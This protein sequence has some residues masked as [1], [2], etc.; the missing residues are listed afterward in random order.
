MKLKHCKEQEEIDTI[1]TVYDEE[2]RTVYL[3]GEVNLNT[4]QNIVSAIRHLDK[5]KGNITFVINSSGG[6]AAAGFAIADA[7]K[8]TKSKVIAVCL[9]E[10]MSI[11]MTILQSCDSRMSAPNCR[12]MIHNGSWSVPDL[13]V[14]Q[15]RNHIK[16]IQALNEQIYDSLTEK[17][18][19]VKSEVEKMCETET[20]MS[21]EL[22]LGYGFIDC[23]LGTEGKK[24]GRK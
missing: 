12:F 15:V 22:A 2:S 4:Y 24:K 23:I 17:S 9:G 13:T 10:C 1:G 7:I 8:L 16:E 18:A 6:E 19:L 11:A 14:S 21:A 3:T 5:T 20:F